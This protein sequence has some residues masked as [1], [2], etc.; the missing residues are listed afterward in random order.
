[1]AWLG[2]DA[3]PINAGWGPAPQLHA[4]DISG[5]VR[6]IQQ[7]RQFEQTNTQKNVADAI[8]QMQQ[9]QQSSAYG[10][11]LQNAG[12][13]PQG[14][15]V[16][17]MSSADLAR[18]SQSI[19]EQT[20][21]TDLDAMHQAMAKYYSNSGGMGGGSSG[22]GSGGV[23]EDQYPPTKDINGVTYYR[24]L[25]AHG[26]INYLPLSPTMQPTTAKPETERQSYQTEKDLA[27]AIAMHQL[28]AQYEAEQNTAL[29]AATK[30]PKYQNV[31]YSGSAEWA[32]QQ[33]ELDQLRQQRANP[34]PNS[35]SSNLAPNSSSSY[36]SPDQI[37][38]ARA[39]QALQDP[40][41]T[42]AEKAQAQKIIDAGSQDDGTTP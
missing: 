23:D 27:S 38:M 11:A 34:A 21:D 16:S 32:A 9:Q 40:Q 20:P 17:G 15:D 4:P 28:R 31:P 5:M 25:D 18:L 8:K 19:Q 29:G 12:V 42:D 3:L 10:Q 36:A 33:A 6:A 22:D 39:R 41:A 13:V 7:Q 37:K 2:T 14:V 30:D 1:M 35:A 24:R 26:R